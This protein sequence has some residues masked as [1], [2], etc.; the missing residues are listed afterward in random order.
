M[1][2]STLRRLLIGDLTFKRLI[3]S[4]L[5]IYFF[6]FIVGLLSPDYLIFRPPEP[7]YNKLNDG[8]FLK[9]SDGTDLYCVY[10]KN[11]D[12]KFTV[13]YCHGNAEDLGQIYPILEE[14]Y[15]KGFSI[16]SYDYRGYGKSKGRP[17]EKKLY[18][19]LNDLYDYLTRT[20]KIPANN[21][22]IH[23]RSV[24]GGLA[25]E[26]AL[27]HKAGGLI[28]ESPFVSAFRVL[29][30]IPIYP[31]D[32]YK[33]LEKIKKINIP[34]LLIHGKKDNVISF[35][36]GKKL[37]DEANPPKDCFWVE[38]AGHNDLDFVAGDKYWQKIKGFEASL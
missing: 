20:L 36:H 23:G 34:V 26:M 9:T 17:V 27:K 5:F 35:W 7:S 3:K 21:I 38:N 33:N 8:L 16:F 14:Y 12:S 24:G 37:F 32:A 28:L 22:I 19:D 6:F 25:T 29:T 1:N 18:N 10:F 15:S 31:F 13:F 2:K 4:F 11:P 30:R